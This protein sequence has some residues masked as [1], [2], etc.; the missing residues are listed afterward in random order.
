M[1]PGC[2]RVPPTLP[3]ALLLFHSYL[4][5]TPPRGA[6]A[7]PRLPSYH[8]SQARCCF[9][10]YLVITPPGALLLF[11]HMAASDCEEG[12]MGMDCVPERHQEWVSWGQVS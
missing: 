5:I 11:H 10:G 2:N 9:H 7:L 3:G 6:A 4:V 8:P 12:S 1:Q